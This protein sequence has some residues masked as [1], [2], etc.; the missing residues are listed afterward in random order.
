[1]ASM[2]M[3]GAGLLVKSLYRL[4]RVDAGFASAG[5][6]KG[7]YQLP[8]SRYPRNFAQFPRWPEQHRFNEELLA[9]VRAM[10]GVEAATL[11][12]SHPL[13]A[14]FTSSITVVGREAEAADWPEPSIRQVAS[15]YFETMQVG[16]QRGRAFEGSDDADATPVAV[17][18]ESARERYFADAD[19]I[20]QQLNLFGAA[21]TI[22]GVV[23][24]ER[25]QGLTK[26]APPGVY[27][28]LAQAPANGGHAVLLRVRG[29]P[30]AYATGLRSALRDLDP[31][32][33]AFG[34][35][36]LPETLAQ[37]IGQQRFTMLVLGSFAAVALLL[38]AVGVHGVLSYSVSQ[39]TSEI[40]IRMALG[41]DGRS[42]RALVL[43]EGA[44]LMV[45]GLAIG[46][47]GAIAMS[48]VLAALLF[49]VSPYDPLTFAAVAASLA[50]VAMV[51]TWL[52]A[53]RAS[54]VDPIVAL[55][56]E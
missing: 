13:D 16:V 48:R 53:R 56:N 8:A 55:R 39:R 45:A 29:E 40:G 41:A 42:V 17:I 37:S 31:Q 15:G 22:I 36:P 52:P 33:P 24:N 54:R 43:G 34:I 21:R 18:N 4:N 50:G 9:R 7:E 5:I 23:A 10:P 11:A 32:L 14:G 1:M 51:A 3:V 28:P 46:L 2:L 19:P 44:W 49:G 35:E 27:L 47:V 25:F 38:A 12:S 20:G 30:E 26:D 6:L